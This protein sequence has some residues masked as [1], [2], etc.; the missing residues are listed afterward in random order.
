MPDEMRGLLSELR[1]DTEPEESEGD[2]E[3]GGGEEGSVSSILLAESGS[4]HALGMQ[5]VH[6]GP[7]VGIYLRSPH[8]PLSEPAAELITSP[9]RLGSSRP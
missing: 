9:P 2:G 1:V 3:R 8:T 4:V 5:S 6:S 7:R